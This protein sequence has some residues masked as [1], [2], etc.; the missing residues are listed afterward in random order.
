MLLNVSQRAHQAFFFNGPE[1]GFSAP[2]ELYEIELHG[3]GLE[4]RGITAP[5]APVVAIGHNAHL[6]FGLT[7]G[8]SQTNALYV[9]H[10]VPGHPEEYFYHGHKRTMSC[11]DETFNYRPPPSSLRM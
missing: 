3:P 7:S 11:R 4:V 10:L 6:A 2:E 8:L 5:G 1:L 9:E